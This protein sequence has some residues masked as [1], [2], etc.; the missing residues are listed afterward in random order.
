[1]PL[2]KPLSFSCQLQ[3]PSRTH[4]N[5]VKG[6]VNTNTASNH[7]K[8]IIAGL[9]CCPF[10]CLVLLN[11]EKVTIKKTKKKEQPISAETLGT[12]TKQAIPEK[13]RRQAEACLERS[14]IRAGIFSALSS[15][16]WWWRWS[17]EGRPLGDPRLAGNRRLLPLSREMISLCFW[18]CQSQ[19]SPAM[20]H[21]LKWSAGFCG[22]WRTLLKRGLRKDYFSSLQEK[23]DIS[24]CQRSHSPCILFEGGFFEKVKG[25]EK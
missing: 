6:H 5:F 9:L 3:L 19:S 20:L 14:T 7:S 4:N 15:Q 21:G 16:S 18:S 11:C 17:S 13:K 8:M 23:G 2:T 1:M 24:E 22:V 25:G 12:K 10:V